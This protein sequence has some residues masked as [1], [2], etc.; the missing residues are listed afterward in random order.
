MKVAEECALETEVVG[1]RKSRKEIRGESAK[2]L[3][4][5]DLQVAYH[6]MSPLIAVQETWHGCTA[7]QHIG[8]VTFLAGSGVVRGASGGLSG[9][10]PSTSRHSLNGDHFGVLT[11]CIALL[12]HT[13]SSAG[14]P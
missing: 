1:W 3:A 4:L 10:R 14:F 12:V 5:I 13:G 7:C 11:C 6:M 2:C 9:R 8:V